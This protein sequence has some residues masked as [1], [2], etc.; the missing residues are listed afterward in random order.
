MIDQ[1]LP[2]LTP[3]LQRWARFLAVLA[4]ALALFWLAHSLSAVLT[5]IVAA[6]AIAYAL[7]PV[8]TWIEHH[9]RIPRFNTVVLGL[10]LLL[11]IGLALLVVGTV[12]MYQ[13]AGNLPRYLR[14]AQHWLQTTAAPALL[15]D[16]QTQARM[17]E[18]AET[19]GGAV[20]AAIVSV[21][22]AWLSNAFY[23]AT[24]VVLL[25]LYTFFC[26]WHF[27]YVVQSVHDHLPEASRETIVR[28]VKTVDRSVS[29]F[30]RGR[31]LVGALVAVALSVGWSIVGLKYSI[32]LGMLGGLLNIAPFISVLSL[33]PAVLVAWSMANDAGA[34]WFYPVVFTIGVYLAVQAVESFVLAP[35]VL[36]HS[37]GLHPL[38]TVIALMVGGELAGMLGLLLAIPIAGTL[39]SL[40]AEF[41]LPEVR[42]L[43]GR[44]DP[45][46]PP[47]DGHAP[48]APPAPATGGTA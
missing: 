20:A 40:V 28:V 25:P 31:L 16:E 36:A 43:A 3:A 5:P 7:N 48:A 10:V 38:T 45:P 27:N 30:F 14:D 42:R 47:G 24:L 35:F 26:L 1:Y 41:V 21:A 29:D 18:L 46:E 34:S 37:S 12:Q 4:A 2:P 15:E 6:M 19:H 9:W 23:A 11:S 13:F 17:K 8:V 44:P 22:G 33:P 39:K 32:A